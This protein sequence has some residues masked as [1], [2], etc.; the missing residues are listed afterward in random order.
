MLRKIA[1]QLKAFATNQHGTTAVTFALSI[2]PMMLMVGAA[3]DYMRYT[4]AETKL[5]AALDSGALA[6]ATT[7]GSTSQK[8]KAGDETMAANLK[9]I[10]LDPGRVTYNFVISGNTVKATARHVM[11]AGFMQIAGLTQFAALAETDISIP[12]SGKVELALVLDYS[13]SMEETA[14]GQVKYVAMKNAASK[15]VTDLDK[16]SPGKVKVALVPFSHHVYVTLPNAYVRGQSGAGS[17]TSCTQDRRYPHN[18]TDATPG[19]DN[20]TKWNQPVANIP[21]QSKWGCDGYAPR[22][23]KLLP[24][25][26]DIAKVKGQLAAMLP[27]QYTNI[28]LGAEFGYHVLSPNAPFSEGASY[29]DTK[30]RKVMVLLTDG[31]QTAPAFGPGVRSVEQGE[32]NLETICENMKASGITIVTIA[33]DLRNAATRQRLSDCSS[34]PSKDFYVAEEGDDLSAAFEDIRRKI[35]AQVFISR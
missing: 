16:A 4:N 33:F 22:N 9:S 14:G 29:A 6:V 7:A 31:R 25:T 28:S 3:V 10:G 2:V 21:Q 35:S 32:A 20:A 8:K 17:W 18:L 13:G 34:D 1:S 11:P 15:L 26:T 24:L 27:Y 30:T 19:T 12:E 23:L 5:Q